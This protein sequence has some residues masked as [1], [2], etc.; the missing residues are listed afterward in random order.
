M[1]LFSSLYSDEKR[2][3]YF[4]A[5]KRN[6]GNTLSSLAFHALFLPPK[7]KFYA[8]PCLFKYKGTNYLFFEDFDYKKGVISYVTLDQGNVVTKPQLALELPIHLSFPHVFQDGDAIYMTPE[9]FRYRSISLYKATQFPHQWAFERVLVRGE[10]FSDPILFKH[11]GYYWLFAAV[12]KDQLVI[13]YAKD[14]HSPFFPHPINHRS[15]KGRNSGPIFFIDGHMI[16]P[17]MD[18]SIR[19]GRSMILNEIV[20]LTTEEFLEKEVVCIEPNWAPGLQ[21]THTYS[22]NEDYV[23]YDGERIIAPFEDALYSSSD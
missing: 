21:G 22:Q 19:Y 6:E 10:N 7:G 13:Y 1:A 11:N 2:S 20:L 4:I 17:T 18:C 5:I 12:R 23:V 9:T 14:L 8:D 16:R 3:K 15:I